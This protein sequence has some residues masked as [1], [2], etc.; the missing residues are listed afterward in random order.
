MLMANSTATEKSR[1]FRCD[2]CDKA[3]A[4]YP[5][6]RR[7]GFRPSPPI[8]A[9][10][11]HARITSAI[12]VAKSRCTWFDINIRFVHA[13]IFLPQALPAEV[14]LRHVLG[15]VVA[16]QLIVGAPVGKAQVEAFIPG[17]LSLNTK[18]NPHNRRWSGRP[19]SRVR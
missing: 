8:H 2:F 9:S 3:R 5:I 13:R 17:T 18:R 6:V 7:T 19:I 1:P 15:R 10:P 11:R 16:L 14:W 4:S 12:A